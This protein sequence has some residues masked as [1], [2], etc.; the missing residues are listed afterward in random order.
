M[1][2]V[3]RSRTTRGVGVRPSGG[4]RTEDQRLLE[5]TSPPAFLDTDTW[6]SLRILGEF[7]EG[8]EELAAVG[9]AVSIFG[10]ARS[11]EDSEEYVASSAERSGWK[12]AATATGAKPGAACTL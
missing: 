9:P 5:R 7:V 2:L 10:S 1:A 6:R 8:F 12:K 3:N 11:A 4:E